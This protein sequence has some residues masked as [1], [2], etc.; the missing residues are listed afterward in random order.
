[1]T[2]PRAQGAG[3][4]TMI[5]AAGGRAIF[6]PTLEIRAPADAGKLR[7]L[8]D[9]LDAF[10]LA[11]FISPNAVRTA[12]AALEAR[13]GGRP[14]PAP[15]RVAAVGEGTRR[16][17]AQRGFTQVLAPEGRADSEALLDLPEL[18]RVAGKNMVIFR[19]EGGRALLADTLRA[20]GA[21]VENAECYRRAQPEADAGALLAAWEA[22]GVQAVTV[23]SGEGLD[24]LCAMIGERGLARLR[25][26]PLF[27]PHARIAGQAA[28]LGLGPAHVAGPGDREML[29]ALVAYFSGAQ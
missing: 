20:R 13:R 25:A 22:G 24:N 28:R 9:R 5:E 29:A 6:F 19:G 11:I 4:V 18:A 15:L 21:Q 17:L 7:A 26:T 23:S 2:R 10:D 16:A 27:V 3:L 12:L 1:V 14:W 8:L